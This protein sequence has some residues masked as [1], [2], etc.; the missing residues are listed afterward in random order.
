[1]SSSDVSWIRAHHNRRLDNPAL[2]SASGDP[3]PPRAFPGVAEGFVNTLRGIN[4]HFVDLITFDFR[5]RK[6]SPLVGAGLRPLPQGR[7]VD[8]APEY[9]PQRGVPADLKPKPR[10]KAT[11][12]SVGP[13]EAAVSF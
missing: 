9:E 3:L 13:F 1:M 12:P 8:L 7:I 5:P 6:D 10:R 2:H 4:P 11:P